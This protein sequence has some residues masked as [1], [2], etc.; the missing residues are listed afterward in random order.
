MKRSATID[1]IRKKNLER[2]SHPLRPEGGR[3]QKQ[4]AF[5]AATEF[6]KEYKDVRLIKTLQDV[7]GTEFFARAAIMLDPLSS[8]RN[9]P[10]LMGADS[11]FREKLPMKSEGNVVTYSKLKSFRNYLPDIPKPQIEFLVSSEPEEVHRFQNSQ[12]SVYYNYMYDSTKKT[13]AA[14]MQGVPHSDYTPG[15]KPTDNTPEFGYMQMFKTSTKEESPGI[16]FRRNSTKYYIETEAPFRLYNRDEFLQTLVL[17]GPCALYSG[18]IFSEDPAAIGLEIMNQN[19]WGMIPQALP[20]K[21]LYNAFYQI[22]ELRDLPGLIRQID[23]LKLLLAKYG[24]PKNLLKNLPG[25]DK[26]VSN[27]YLAWEFGVVSVDQAVLGLMKLPQKLAKRINYLIRKNGK[28]I[29]GRAKREFTKSE[30]NLP[31][32]ELPSFEFTLPDWVTIQ[33]ESVKRDQFAEMRVVINS[34]VR[35]P[36][37]AVP[38][39][40]NSNYLDLIGLLPRPS[41][42]YDLT[43]WTWLIGWFT[44]MNDYI[45]V[46]EA[47]YQENSLINYGFVTVVF[48]ETVTHSCEFKVTSGEYA[49]TSVGGDSTVETI[50]EHVTVYPYRRV[51][52][53]QYQR[54][55]SIADLD[56]VKAFG[57]GLT[58][59]LSAFQKQ[60]LGSL[61]TQGTQPRKAQ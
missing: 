5:D 60:I 16:I 45:K 11:R 9:V 10:G 50:D 1:Q 56:G 53:S 54:R 29:K 21:R 61:I 15:Y 32:Y 59:S 7:F 40:E 46:M 48:T 17:D 39:Y 33:N 36:E 37:V 47:I 24:K 41:D 30:L 18:P 6:F 28:V 43:P 4:R 58:D 49:V 2:Q 26:E 20:S 3:S 35:F 57:F 31:E 51:Y 25:I 12:T 34:T 8:F 27:L 42:F 55:V 22:G 52:T 23:S 38:S 14:D 19:I 13:R 44:G